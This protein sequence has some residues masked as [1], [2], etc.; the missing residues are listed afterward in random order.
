[1]S[2]TGG[3]GT[4]ESLPRSDSETG[5]PLPLV[6]VVI[7]AYRCAQYI[8]QTV[9]S[10]LG[11]SYRECEVL[12]IND[13]SPDTPL[14]EKALEPFR[15]RIVY[16]SQPGSGPSSARNRGII[17]ARGQYI[18]FLD[19]DDYWAPNHLAKRMEL[20]RQ[21]PGL[22]LVY[23][24]CILL[25]D[26]TSVGRA[27]SLQPQAARV[28]F[29]ALVVEDC[30]IGTSTAVVLREAIV[31]AGLFDESF[32]RCED[33]EM[34]LRM[35]LGG[36][37]MAYHSDADVFHRVTEHGLSADRLAMKRDRIRVYEKLITTVPLSRRQRATIESLAADTRRGCD[38]DILKHLLEAED[39]QN[40]VVV[41]G[42]V[43]ARG[44]S[45]KLTLAYMG[46]RFAPRLFGQ[47]HRIRTRFIRRRPLAGGPHLS[48]QATPV[49]AEIRPPTETREPV[50]GISSGR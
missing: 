11:Q 45:W 10:V 1:M 30:A 44:S 16:I 23:C 31:R 48:P 3:G 46:L 40:A 42:R 41:A 18:A 27:F 19:A 32:G 21:D 29:D 8:A 38:V 39:Y 6:S 9:E 50:E 28:S 5:V 4:V 14:L 35:S 13:G 2:G 37:R 47:L 34:W 17:Q 12:V 7:P 22:E 49:P 15:D 36:S 26:E 24:D 33:F 25:K 43:N 20:F